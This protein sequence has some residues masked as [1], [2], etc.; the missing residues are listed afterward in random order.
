MFHG[1]GRLECELA[2]NKSKTVLSEK[3]M[4]VVFDPTKEIVLHIDSS[5]YEV[6]AVLSH[7]ID[8]IEGIFGVKKFHKYLYGLPFTIVISD[9]LV[10]RSKTLPHMASSRILRWAVIFCIQL[11][12]CLQEGKAYSPCRCNI[13]FA[14]YCS[15]WS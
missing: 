12:N 3:A 10:L 8:E 9:V 15:S 11:F 13:T 1:S 6:A 4:V 14:H 2:F 7:V 5:G